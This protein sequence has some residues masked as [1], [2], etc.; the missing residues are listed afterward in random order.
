M[1]GSADNADRLGVDLLFDD[2]A[3]W[4]GVWVDLVDAPQ[5]P[6]F[7]PRVLG[8]A[9]NWTSGGYA[10]IPI[11]ELLPNTEYILKWEVEIGVVMRAKLWKV[12]DVEPDWQVSIPD[13]GDATFA[14]VNSEVLLYSVMYHGFDQTKRFAYLDV[15][16]GG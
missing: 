13:P 3:N 5:D 6:F 10:T 1:A 11:D 9:A 4:R 15:H 7:R 8:V 12:G 16:D 2:F 14:G